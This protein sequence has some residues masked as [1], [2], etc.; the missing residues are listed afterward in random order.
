MSDQA[1]RCW[2]NQ[3]VDTWKLIVAWVGAVLITTAI[4]WQI[5]SVADSQVSARPVEVVA[6]TSTSTTGPPTSSLATTTTTVPASS[7]S[8]TSPSGTTTATP[9]SGATDDGQ[10]T[11]RTVSSAGGNVVIRHRPGEVELQAATPALGFDVEIDDAGPQRVRVEFES[12][13]SDVRVEAEWRNG[14]L[15]VS[16]TGD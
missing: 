3:H 6:I 14:V 9:A 16:I 10:W 12:E 4:T 13:D 2:D 15:E 8:S 5:V 11:V 7:T 1:A